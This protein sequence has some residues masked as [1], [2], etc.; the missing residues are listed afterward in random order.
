MA[1]S[2]RLRLPQPV[3]RGQPRRPRSAMSRMG[4]SRGLG[5]SGSAGLGTAAARGGMI[6]SGG[7]PGGGGLADG[8]AIVGPVCDPA[9]EDALGPASQVRPLRRIL[10]MPFGQH[11]RRDLAGIGVHRQVPL[12][13]SPACP[14]VP[15]RI[16]LA[17]AEQRQA[18]AVQYEVHWAVT[19]HGSVAGGRRTRVHACSGSNGPACADRAR[20]VSA[21]SW[22]TPRPGAGRDKT[23]GEA[24]ARVRLPGRHP[25]ADHPGCYASALPSSPVRPHPVRA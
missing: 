15:G 14:T 1:V 3:A 6:T 20:A 24:S 23:P 9:G 19:W 12:H 11:V 17:R 22:P 25:R 5:L 8:I 4:R 21:R 18:S 13:P 7:W 10:G 16:P 2:A